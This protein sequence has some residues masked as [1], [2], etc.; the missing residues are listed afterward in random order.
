[1][2]N[3]QLIDWRCCKSLPVSDLT[4][5]P[6]S[7]P[8]EVNE[9]RTSKHD[10]LM[11]CVLPQVSCLL[12]LQ[13]RGQHRSPSTGYF[14]VSWS[15]TWSVRQLRVRMLSVP[16]FHVHACSHD[17]KHSHTHTD[18]PTNPKNHTHARTSEA[19]KQAK[20]HTVIHAHKYKHTHTQTK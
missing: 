20:T 12:Q 18:R 19:H 2:L 10:N 9:T 1:M 13:S 14:I 5:L 7:M 17:P 8:S 15:Q 16:P 11:K 4:Y 3:L 6:H